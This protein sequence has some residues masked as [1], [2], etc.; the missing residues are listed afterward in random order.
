MKRV[1]LSIIFVSVISFAF[2]QKGEV[3][4]AKKKWEF[5]YALGRSNPIPKKMTQLKI[6]LAHTDKAIANEES[7]I[8]P[9]AWAY[10]ALAA[11]EIAITDTI[12]VDNI[13][14]N[15]K[16]A[17]E[18]LDQIKPLDPKNSQKE[19]VKTIKAN[20]A[21][22]VRNAAIISYQ[23]KDFKM[24]YEK[25]AELTKIN[26]KD[27]AMYMNAGVSAYASEDFANAVKYYK[28]AI[29]LNI[30]QSKELYKDAISITLMKLKDTTSAMELIK[31]A[32]LKYPE[33]ISFITSEA[34]IYLKRGQIAESEIILKKLA[35]KDPKNSNY[36]GLLGNVYLQQ[37]IDLQQKIKKFG[38]KEKIDPKV[39]KA[40][41]DYS[42]ERD[43]LV[44]KSM[45][46][47]LKAV[48]LDG[49]NASALEN[50]KTIYF[51]KNDTKNWE[52]I[53]KRIDGLPKK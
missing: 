45:P 12:D 26:P 37:A 33:E 7:K 23:K 41:D 48:E 5:Y 8:L 53:K 15:L 47:F 27:T 30:P 39:K 21:A 22:A 36:Q 44:E 49:K 3:N 13:N 1:V 35:E 25:F 18:A 4:D 51:F 24:A 32:N 40:N 10:R 31:A 38:P 34:D 42:A 9:T 6:V 50:L 2:A 28:K 43:K 52:I 29:S 19:N 20:I 17:K 11:S 46:Y 14:N 16:I